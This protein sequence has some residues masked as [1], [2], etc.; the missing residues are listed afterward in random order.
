M[1]QAAFTLLK[2]DLC[3]ASPTRATRYPGWLDDRLMTPVRVAKN[4]I[5]TAHSIAPL[6]LPLRLRRL[7]GVATEGMPTVA[8]FGHYAA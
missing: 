4:R 1:G 5:G 7:G 6:P 8:I 2:T 3:R